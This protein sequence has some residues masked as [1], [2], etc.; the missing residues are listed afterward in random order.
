MANWK[1]QAAKHSQL[2]SESSSSCVMQHQV[3]TKTT[4]RATTLQDKLLYWMHFIVDSGVISKLDCPALAKVRWTV[5]EEGHR[6]IAK[7][8]ASQLSAVQPS[9]Q[10]NTASGIVGDQLPRKPDWTLMWV[11]H[12]KCPETTIRES[13]KCYSSSSFSDISRFS[14]QFD[15]IFS[16]ETFNLIF[17]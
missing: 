16:W 10:Q 3:G 17:S 9:P 12:T 6:Q 11:Y 5:Q 13:N 2:N 1:N 14:T 8:T 15:W 7:S 4:A